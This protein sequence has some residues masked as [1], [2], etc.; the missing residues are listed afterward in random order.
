MTTPALAPPPLDT[1][2]R[3]PVPAPSAPRTRPVITLPLSHSHS[4]FERG[5]VGYSLLLHLAALALLLLLIRLVPTPAPVVRSTPVE[6]VDYVEL[7]WPAGSPSD[8]AGAES[9]PAPSPAAPSAQATP[10]RLPSSRA[11]DFPSGVPTG[12][13]APGS[14]G[15]GSPSAGGAADGGAG[16][17][18]DRLRP[19]FRDPRLYVAPGDLPSADKSNQQKYMEHLTARI[20][21]S[22]DSAAAAAPRRPDWSFKDAKG[23]TWGMNDKGLHLGP[24]TV[25]RALIPN[26]RSSGTNKEVE[27]AR[28]AQ[29][30][31]DEIQRQETDRAQR[32][33]QAE[34][35]KRQRER[36]DA[37][38]EKSKQ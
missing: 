18:G 17:V 15:V 29:R 21:A 26:A 38:R 14:S 4:P 35:I 10:R 33:A 11:V 31:R 19:G 27:A 23:R 2:Q 28:E 7:D 1:R 20:N 22:N 25:P 12:I 9:S 5:P 8:G 32:E 34:A 36:A 6:R 24:I 37:E 16:G 13:S 30:Q 3:A